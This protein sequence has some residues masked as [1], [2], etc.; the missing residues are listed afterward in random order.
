LERQF[1]IVSRR[2][3]S[4]HRDVMAPSSTERFSDRVENYIRYRP[5]YPPEIVPL[6]I[7]QASLSPASLIADIGSGTGI[8]AEMFLRAGYQVIGVEPNQAMRDAAESLLRSYPAF[9]SVNGTASATT[10]ESQ[11]VDLII[12]AQAFHWFAGKN[13]RDEFTRI[14]KPGGHISLIWNVRQVDTTPFLRDYEA[15]LLRFG[16]DYDT[17]RHETIDARVLGEFF[18]G[19][20]SVHTFA[21][22]QVFDHESLRGRLLS[23]SYAPG[24][25][26]PDHAAMLA[27][28]RRIFD[29]HQRDGVVVIHYVTEVYF[30]N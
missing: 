25:D 10:L 20:Y 12:A 2:A 7:Q 13:T 19:T 1:T 9:T 14:L 3:F 22:Q 4:F 18:A 29:L 28:L 27:E 6:L 26:H 24:P 23:S 11:S 15:L 16:T 5:G 21:N 30:G 8:S 17:V